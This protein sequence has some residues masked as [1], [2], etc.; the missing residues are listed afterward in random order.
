MPVLVMVAR[1][2]SRTGSRFLSPGLSRGPSSPDERR[3]VNPLLSHSQ[4][5]YGEYV[6]IGEKIH[7]SF[8]L[9]LY[10]QLPLMECM[11]EVRE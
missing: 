9:K 11:C 4:C 6:G 1:D 5:L 10:Q 2:A 7:I 3:N 8:H